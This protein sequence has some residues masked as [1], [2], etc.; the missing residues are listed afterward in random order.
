MVEFKFR[1]GTTLNITRK[2]DFIEFKEEEECQLIDI[3]IIGKLVK[4]KT[5]PKYRVAL[6]HK[7]LPSEIIAIHSMDRDE[8]DKIYQFLKSMLIRGKDQTAGHF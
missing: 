3:N 4:E 6:R 8:A 1:N 5:F 2:R 7:I